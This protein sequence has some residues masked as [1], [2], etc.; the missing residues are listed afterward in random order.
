MKLDEMKL[1]LF[2]T[3]DKLFMFRISSSSS[4]P[5]VLHSGIRIYVDRYCCCYAYG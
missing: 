5:T 1:P 3:D 2:V 4:S